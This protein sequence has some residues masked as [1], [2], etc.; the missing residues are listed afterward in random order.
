MATTNSSDLLDR[1]GEQYADSLPRM[2]KGDRFTG[3]VRGIDSRTGEFSVY[4]ILTVE[5]EHV[6]LAKHP[7]LEPGLVSWH[8]LHSVAQ[9]K[10][11]RL[12]VKPGETVAVEYLG[13]RESR[14]GRG[15][16]HDWNVVTDRQ[17]EEFDWSTF[18]ADTADD[19]DA[20]SDIPSDLPST[21]DARPDDFATTS[22]ES[23]PF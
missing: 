15:S 17:R 13:Q 2:S 7:D 6:E 16:Y 19:A 1:L 3:K 18:G 12:G 11:A 23:I 10:L 20:V 8:V 9:S 21:A 4:P 14:N 5:L 22:D